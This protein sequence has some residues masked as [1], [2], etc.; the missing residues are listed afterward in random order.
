M[1]V[2]STQRDTERALYYKTAAN[3]ECCG[4]WKLTEGRKE[5][6]EREGGRG[7]K[8]E[9][10]EMCVYSLTYERERA[11]ERERERDREST[12]M[13]FYLKNPT[14]IGSH[15]SN[16]IGICRQQNDTL[17]THKEG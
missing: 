5:G 4:G 8:R 7:S 2:T 13:E 16:L 14:P 12:G 9:E 10:G 6:G 17:P 3:L 15:P 1:T 11:R